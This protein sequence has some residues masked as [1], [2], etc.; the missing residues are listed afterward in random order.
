[1]LLATWLADVQDVRRHQRPAHHLLRQLTR[2]TPLRPLLAADGSLVM[3]Y[4]IRPEIL[5]EE[6]YTLALFHDLD[7][8][9][10]GRQH[11]EGWTGPARERG[12]AP[13]AGQ[14]F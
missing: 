3:E 12:R 14:L 4:N 11:R 2:Q 6:Y 7:G 5:P 8:L 13:R 10:T 9:A 1:V